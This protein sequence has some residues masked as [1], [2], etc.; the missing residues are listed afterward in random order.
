MI[1][2]LGTVGPMWHVYVMMIKQTDAWRF[3]GRT[4]K[5]ESLHEFGQ[6]RVVGEPYTPVRVSQKYNFA[7][8]SV[9]SRPG[10]AEDGL[11]L[12]GLPT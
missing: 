8:A 1:N 11:L 5:R 4:G 2:P 3:R 6:D 12:R 9:H 7:G 10:Y